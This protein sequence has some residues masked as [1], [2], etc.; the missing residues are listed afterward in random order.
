MEAM[1]EELPASLKELIYM[2]RPYA[3]AG[4]EGH[5]G[6]AGSLRPLWRGD[7]RQDPGEQAASLL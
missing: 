7:P 4:D 5:D 6:G 3:C 2:L 1:M